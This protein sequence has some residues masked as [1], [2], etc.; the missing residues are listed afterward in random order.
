MG[1]VLINGNNYD[2]LAFFVATNFSIIY[3]KRIPGFVR[4]GS[5]YKHYRTWYLSF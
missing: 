4:G 2:E 1:D 3:N 5:L